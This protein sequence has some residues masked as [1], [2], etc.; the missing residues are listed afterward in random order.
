MKGLVFGCLATAA[1]LA[2]SASA[3]PTRT[4][5]ELF[6]IMDKN[7]NSRVTRSEF[8]GKLSGEEAAKARRHFE[9]LDRDGS[10]SL[11]FIEFASRRNRD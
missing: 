5:E 3:A 2:G 6:K 8:V 10:G 1:F 4:L 11:T 7:D 9:K